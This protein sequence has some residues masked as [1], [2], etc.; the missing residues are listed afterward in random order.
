MRRPS[1]FGRSTTLIWPSG[2]SSSMPALPW[3]WTYADNFD[4]MT[5][6]K[7]QDLLNRRV[8]QLKLKTS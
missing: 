7:A 5:D 3:S 4:K 1:A 2:V 6:A 8:E